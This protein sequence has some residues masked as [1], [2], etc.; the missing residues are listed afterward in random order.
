MLGK[1]G[2]SKTGRILL[3]T[4]GEENKAPYVA[5]IMKDILASGVV[6]HTVAYGKQASK[7]LEDVSSQ[8]GD[9]TCAIVV[10]I[11]VSLDDDG[12]FI[13]LAVPLESILHLV[14]FKQFVYLATSD[15]LS[16]RC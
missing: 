16:K 1:T 13:L 4:D 15:Q 6:V 2:D 8:T 12:Y 5:S 9:P 3:M 11:L 14:V 10:N 7:T